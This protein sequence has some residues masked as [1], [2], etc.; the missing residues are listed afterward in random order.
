MGNRLEWEVKICGPFL[1]IVDVRSGSI[2]HE[3]CAKVE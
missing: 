3:S 1:V 2:E